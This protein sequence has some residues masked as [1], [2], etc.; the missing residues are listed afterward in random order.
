[1]TKEQSV[2]ARIMKMFSKEKILLQHSVLSYSI[3][4]YLLKHKLAIVV[5]EKGHKDREEHK[6]IERQR[7][8]KKELDCKFIG[9]NPDKKDFDIDIDIGEI[10]S[11]IN[12]SY[13]KSLKDK[14]SKRPSELNLVEVI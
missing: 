10:Y 6:E 7:A 9:I 11:H 4:L 12:K 8:I 5:D 2:L 3:D 1:M 13:E 14:I